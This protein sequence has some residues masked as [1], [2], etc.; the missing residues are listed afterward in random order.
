M[1]RILDGISFFFAIPVVEQGAG[2]HQQLG[3]VVA[4]HFSF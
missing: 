2:A 4:R 1:N 3:G